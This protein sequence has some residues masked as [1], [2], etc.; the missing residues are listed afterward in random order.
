MSNRVKDVV[1]VGMVSFAHM[2]AYSYAAAVKSLPGVELVGISDEEAGRGREAAERFGTEY[3]GGHQALLARDLDAVI[4]CSTNADHAELTIAAARAGK[5]VLVEKP[6]ATNAPDARRMIAACQAS[7]VQ[8][9]V[10]FPCRYQPAV[11]RV[12]ELIDQGAIG[13]VVAIKG[14]NHGRMP[15]GWFV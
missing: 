12:K 13:R 6:I 9:Q 1:K 14:T 8:L 7:G 5:H 11:A 3:V 10:A 2:H 4:I 15:G